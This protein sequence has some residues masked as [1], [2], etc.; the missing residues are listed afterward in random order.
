M[1]R[2]KSVDAGHHPVQNLLSSCMLSKNM[3]KRYTKLMFCPA[4]LMG[5]KHGL[6]Y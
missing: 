5:V 1:S 2:L 6:L 3:M 4:V